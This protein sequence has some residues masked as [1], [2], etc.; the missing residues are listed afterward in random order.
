MRIAIM[1]AGGVGGYFGGLL[2]RAGE[3]VT[4]IARG[5]HRQAIVKNG[6]QIRSPKG[7]FSVNVAATDNPS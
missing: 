5:Q 3:D 2:A 7:D 4:L 1:G 6:L